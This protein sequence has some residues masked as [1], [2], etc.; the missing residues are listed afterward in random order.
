MK[1]LLEISQEERQRIL[2]MHNL[3][4][5]NEIAPVV[6]PVA[7]AAGAALAGLA[8]VAMNWY[9]ESSRSGAKN[10][11]KGFFDICNNS[12]VQPTIQSNK[13][14][15]DLRDAIEYETLWIFGG[16]DEEGI[17]KALKSLP[18]FDDFCRVVKSYKNSYQKDLFEDLDDDVSN[19]EME[20]FMRPLRDILEKQQQAAQVVAAQKQ[21][22]NQGKGP[23]V[24]NAPQRL[25]FQ[26]F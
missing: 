3:S 17:E 5:I 16:T 26:K 11:V 21:P 12:N 13:I 10:V 15:D 25:P 2:E 1:R 20:K 7:Y 6:V 22:F 4:N 14:A 23:T 18:T 9:N 19:S 24:N 8:G